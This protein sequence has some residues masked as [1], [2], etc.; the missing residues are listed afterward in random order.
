[1][2]YTCV[3]E[4]PSTYSDTSA[5]L[6]GGD[7]LT[8]FTELGGNLNFFFPLGPQIQRL[9]AFRQDAFEAGALGGA[10]RRDLYSTRAS[11][12]QTVESK[13]GMGGEW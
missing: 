11:A 2:T 7:F 9:L 12:W 6:Y 4:K 3:Y 1:M 5:N 8:R 13:V 10:R